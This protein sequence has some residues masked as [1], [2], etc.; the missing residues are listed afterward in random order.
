MAECDSRNLFLAGD[1]KVYC[2]KQDDM[3]LDY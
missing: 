2:V 1:G 3:E